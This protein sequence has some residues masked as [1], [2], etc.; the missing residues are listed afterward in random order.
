MTMIVNAFYLG[1][2]LQLMITFTQTDNRSPLTA[3]NEAFIVVLGNAIRKKNYAGPVAS[4]T[5][6]TKSFPD[7]VRHTRTGGRG[8]PP[9]RSG[10]VIFPSPCFSKSK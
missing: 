6:Y 4:R 2:V 3:T 8:H 9:P 1:K 10:G 5:A 7:R